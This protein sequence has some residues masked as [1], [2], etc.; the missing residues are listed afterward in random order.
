MRRDDDAH[1]DPPLLSRHPSLIHKFSTAFQH[2]KSAS[3]S[4]TFAFVLIQTHTLCRVSEWPI[5]SALSRGNA[6]YEGDVL[7]FSVVSS[8]YLLK[9]PRT[10]QS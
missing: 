7:A 4:N 10:V 3:H 2:R 6:I 5:A 1:G 9:S 8:L